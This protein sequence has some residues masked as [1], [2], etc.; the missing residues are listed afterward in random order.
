MPGP[1]DK[2]KYPESYRLVELFAD[3]RSERIRTTVKSKL[4]DSLTE[5]EAAQLCRRIEAYHRNAEER[6]AAQ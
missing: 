3:P 2:A 6:R 1:P 4:G 5:P